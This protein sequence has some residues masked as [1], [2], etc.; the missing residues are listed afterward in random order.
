MKRRILILE[1]SSKASHRLRRAFDHAEVESVL[2]ARTMR[3]ACEAL[4]RER[5]DLVVIPPDHAEHQVNVFR[6]IQPG[7]PI[8]VSGRPDDMPQNLKPLVQAIVDTSREQVSISVLKPP[9]TARQR[10]RSATPAMS[11]VAAASDI[12]GKAVQAGRAPAEEWPLAPAKAAATV[13]GRQSTS[14]LH[15]VSLWE[16][17]FGLLAFVIPRLLFAALILIFIIFFTYLGLDMAGGTDFWTALREA[18]PNTVAYLGRL[19]QGDLGMTTTASGTARPVPIAEVLAIWLPRSLGLLAI[20]LIFASVVGVLL[21]VRAATRGAAHSL[22]IIVATIV[23]VSV[24][25]FFAAFLLQWLVINA[26]QMAGRTLLPA[27]GFGWDSHLILPGL[28]LAARPLAQ[29]TR[30]TFVS[31]GDVLREDFV[32]TARSKGLRGHQVMFQHVMR[33]AAIPIL[34]TMGVSLRFALTTLPIVE[35][36]FGWLGAGYLLLKS[37][38]QQDEELTIALVLCLGLL[39]IIVN[40]I[41]EVSYRFLD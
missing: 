3:E 33:N 11:P 20:S 36:Y 10:V 38:G 9:P 21:G 4:G 30:I 28:V 39:F 13:A 17:I 31:V 5:Y 22:T 34:T 26:T 8:A 23:G 16:P 2:Q 1:K 25:S 35:F 18:V 40:F 12:G 14:A 27:G 15:R 7:V 6:A 24:P 41:L 29:I 37:I 32:R 19:M